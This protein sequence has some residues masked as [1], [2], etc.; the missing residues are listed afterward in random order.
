MARTGIIRIAR[1]ALAAAAIVA[2]VA[3]SAAAQAFTPAQGEGSVSML[4]QDQF[5]KYHMAPTTEVDAGP[6]YARS[7]LLDVTY[8]LTDKIAVSVGLPFVGTRYGGSSPHPLADL[9]GPNPID[10]GSWHTTAQDFRFDVRYNVTRNLMN[11]GVVLTPYVGSITPSHDYPYFVHSGFGRDLR[12]VQIGASVAKLFEKGIPGLLIQGRYGYG[13]V[14]QVVDISHN[15]SLGS[16]E[17]A[18]FATPNLRLM[19]LSSGQ[20]THGGIDFA[21]PPSIPLLTRD[22]YLHHDQIERDNMLSVGGGASYAIGE[23]LDIYG[24]WMRTVA[25]RNGHLL[26]RGISLGVSWSF[27]TA[28]ARKSVTATAEN[29]LAR[30]LCEKGTK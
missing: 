27:T 7:L 9:S 8:G 4:Y 19:A 29:S 15:R 30:C 23:T 20:V 28:H 16:L 12:E 5:F 24:S 21:G 11:K 26:D 1:A 17:A 25:Q 3:P 14:E 6:I 18:Y 13:F 10:D 2:L 22:Q